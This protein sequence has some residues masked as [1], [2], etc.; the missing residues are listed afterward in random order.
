MGK[1]INMD[2]AK[3]FKTKKRGS[4]FRARE[5]VEEPEEDLL[6][7]YYDKMLSLELKLKNDLEQ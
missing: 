4:T 1:I 2:G 7:K 5:A 6:Q 3:R